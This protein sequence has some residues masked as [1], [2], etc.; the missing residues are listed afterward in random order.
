MDRITKFCIKCGK[1]DTEFSQDSRG[2]EYFKKVD[3]TGVCTENIFLCSEC[4]GNFEYVKDITD[5]LIALQNACATIYYA[6]QEGMKC[7]H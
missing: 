3:E 5:D 4:I 6:A 2:C 7:G 1:P